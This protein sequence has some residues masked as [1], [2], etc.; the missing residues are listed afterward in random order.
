MQRLAAGLCATHSTERHGFVLSNVVAGEHEG[1]EVDW[2]R[3]ASD[4]NVSIAV[5]RGLWE[6]ARATAPH[7]P[8]QAERTFRGLL[9]EAAAANTTHEPGRETLVDTNGVRDAASLGPGKSTRVVDEQKAG[10]PAGTAKQSSPGVGATGT[11]AI[12]TRPTSSAE[13]LRKDLVTAAQASKNLVD[14]L[15]SSDP[16]TIVDALREVR[17]HEGP[18]VLQKI[19]SLAGGAIETLPRAASARTADDRIGNRRGDQEAGWASGR[20]RQARSDTFN[21]GDTCEARRAT[22]ATA[23]C[24]ASAIG[25]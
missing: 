17:A 2:R 23:W 19:M 6:R 7:D 9:D 21:T 8:K 5:A 20:H 25:R 24:S 22:G 12:A 16:A 15:K 3:I 10:G 11:G 18:P 4:R 14:L 13:G 1:G